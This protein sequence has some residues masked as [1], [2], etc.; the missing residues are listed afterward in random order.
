MED[1]TRTIKA[2]K[3]KRQVVKKKRKTTFMHVSKGKTKSG[4]KLA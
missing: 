3:T 1:G 2:A 4:S